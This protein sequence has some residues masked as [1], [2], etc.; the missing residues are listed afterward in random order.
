MVASQEAER[1]VTMPKLFDRGNKEIVQLYKHEVERFLDTSEI[2][3]KLDRIVDG[4]D[5][6]AA[7]LAIFAR[8]LASKYGGEHINEDGTLKRTAKQEAS[9][10]V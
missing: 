6:D 1:N 8:A 3:K 7:N 10:S 2:A 5:D 9:D 4:G